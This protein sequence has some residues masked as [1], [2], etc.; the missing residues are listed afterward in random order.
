MEDMSVVWWA[1]KPTNI[2]RGQG[3]YNI[4]RV[5]LES[6]FKKGLTLDLSLSGGSVE[7]GRCVGIH[8]E[9]ETLNV[10]LQINQVSTLDLMNWCQILKWNGLNCGVVLFSIAPVWSAWA[11]P[12][13]R[14]GL[15]PDFLLLHSDCCQ[16]GISQFPF[17]KL[18]EQSWEVVWNDVLVQ[19]RNQK[20]HVLVSKGDNLLPEGWVHH[21]RSMACSWFA[22]KPQSW[23]KLSWFCQQRVAATVGGNSQL[24]NGNL[25]DPQECLPWSKYWGIDNFRQL[26]Y[27]RLPNRVPS[28]EGPA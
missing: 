7:P 12:S 23:W 14:P 5:W 1:Y 3:L 18:P 25:L 28:N 10:E 24:G 11:P 15:Q 17:P 4:S 22:G 26:L 9:V 27:P 19:L 13:H 6:R 21:P 8:L 16:Y 2:L 20:G